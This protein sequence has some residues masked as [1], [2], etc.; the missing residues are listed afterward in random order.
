[1]KKSTLITENSEKLLVG[2]SSCPSVLHFVLR[3]SVE[4]KENLECSPL[5]EPCKGGCLLR[6]FRS[7]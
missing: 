3:L 6:N 7:S 2:D 5:G 4:G 1:M